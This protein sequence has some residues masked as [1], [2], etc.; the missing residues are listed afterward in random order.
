MAFDKKKKKN[1]L[2]QEVE[3]MFK[4]FMFLP[5]QTCTEIEG[6]GESSAILMM[7]SV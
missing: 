6:S 2:L 7:K 1:M 5:R 3:K 4:Q